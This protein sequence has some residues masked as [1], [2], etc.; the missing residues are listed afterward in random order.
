[1]DLKVSKIVK[2]YIV[3]LSFHYLRILYNV[4]Q[5]LPSSQSSQICFP[6]PT[7]LFFQSIN[8]NLCCPY[9]YKCVAFHWSLADLSGTPL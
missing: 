5:Y 9:T 3:L 7:V 1:M 2:A 6:F 4:F 8:S